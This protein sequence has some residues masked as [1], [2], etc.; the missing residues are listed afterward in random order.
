MRTPLRKKIGAAFV[1]QVVVEAVW[2]RRRGS[3]RGLRRRARLAMYSAPWRL[4]I[5]ILLAHRRY[6]RPGLRFLYRAEVREVM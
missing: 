2:P 5:Q 4:P 3:G 6:G 1:I